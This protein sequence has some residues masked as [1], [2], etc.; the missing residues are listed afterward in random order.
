MNIISEKNVIEMPG[1]CE[2]SNPDNDYSVYDYDYH[3]DYD[4]AD[5]DKEQCLQTC[6]QTKENK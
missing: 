6:L 2:F 5:E 4:Y 3:Y 1:S